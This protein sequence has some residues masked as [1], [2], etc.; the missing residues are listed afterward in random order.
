[1]NI[2]HMRAH[3]AYPLVLTYIKDYSISFLNIIIKGALVTCNSFDLAGKYAIIQVI[4][5]FIA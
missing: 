1:M 3:R 4:V 2:Q 5:F